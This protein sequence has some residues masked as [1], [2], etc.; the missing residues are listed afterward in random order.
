MMR[1][2]LCRRVSQIENLSESFGIK[3]AKATIGALGLIPLGLPHHGSMKLIRSSTLK[4]L[5]LISNDE[6][7]FMPKSEPIENLSERFGIKKAKAT[8]GALGLIPLGLPLSR[9]NVINL[10]L[11]QCQKRSSNEFTAVFT[12]KYLISLYLKQQHFFYL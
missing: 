5:S 4:V 3:K 6:A 11:L 10:V 2:F 1:L 8:I 7:F 9:I 12:T